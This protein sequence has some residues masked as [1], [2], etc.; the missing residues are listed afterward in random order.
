M[1]N[2]V[3]FEKEQTPSVDALFAY[4]G[5]GYSRPQIQI[6]TSSRPF[7]G[8]IRAGHRTDKE[9]LGVHRRK[10]STRRSPSALRS[11]YVLSGCMHKSK[12]QFGC[13]RSASV[14]DSSKAPRFF[15]EADLPELPYSKQT[16]S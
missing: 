10:D 3:I 13:E 9:G 5:G 6:H 11:R 1:G 2:I 16:P 15:L 8:H 7:R 4:E 14:E 12:E